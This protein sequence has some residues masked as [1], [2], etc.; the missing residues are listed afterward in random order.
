[1]RLEAPEATRD[2]A[3]WPAAIAL[4]DAVRV[5]DA[6]AR[7]GDGV[8]AAALCT[9]DAAGGATAQGRV[10]AALG[11]EEAAGERAFLGAVVWSPSFR[12]AAELVAR[13]MSV[14]R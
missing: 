14:A 7:L 4:R 13:G 3:T 11:F 12:S 2:H 9:S 8:L 5:Y 6:C 1:M 10:A